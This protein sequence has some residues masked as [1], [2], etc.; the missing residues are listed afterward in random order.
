MV[1][2]I[3]AIDVIEKIKEYLLQ[4]A[5]SLEPDLIR[6]KEASFE[7][8]ALSFFK[9]QF[10]ATVLNIN[11]Q[12]SSGKRKLRRIFSSLEELSSS[13]PDALDETVVSEHLDTLYQSLRVSRR[14]ALKSSFEKFESFA[15][16]SGPV[17]N[18][19]GEQL[20]SWAAGVQVSPGDPLSCSGP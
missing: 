14:E 16:T 1:D 2:E 10:L 18:S 3:Q 8:R 5:P 4:Q 17:D 7:N 11:D 12:T 15:Q 6:L 20:R 19:F 13:P 9:T